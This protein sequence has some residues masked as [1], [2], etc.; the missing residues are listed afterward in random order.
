[1]MNKFLGRLASPRNVWNLTT[2]EFEGKIKEWDT[3]QRLSKN[4]INK[5]DRKEKTNMIQFLHSNKSLRWQLSK[6]EIQSNSLFENVFFFSLGNS[7][8]INR[9]IVE[10]RTI[11]WNYVTHT[12]SSLHMKD[13]LHTKWQKKIP[14][15]YI[16]CHIT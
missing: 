3:S 12:H 6:N 8:N 9:I 10:N 13:Y 15:W 14:I 7:L 2:C 5:V 16:E 11:H 4:V 1:M